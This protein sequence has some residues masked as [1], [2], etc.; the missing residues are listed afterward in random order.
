MR[1]FFLL[2]LVSIIAQAQN[3]KTHVNHRNE[4][5]LCGVFELQELEKDSLYSS[6]YHDNYTGLEAIDSNASSVS[7]LESTTVDIYMGTWCG[8]CKKWVPRFVRLWD[9]L[10]LNRSQLKFIALYD[11]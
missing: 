8:E 9:D 7:E 4:K 10:G 6:W 11:S 2:F 1:T 3:A 5:H